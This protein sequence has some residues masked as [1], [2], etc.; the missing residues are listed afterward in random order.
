MRNRLIE[1]LLLIFGPGV[2]FAQDNE[3]IF[4]LIPKML[5]DFI[6]GIQ[7]E[8][9][10]EWGLPFFTKLKEEY[11]LKILSMTQGVN[12]KMEMEMNITIWR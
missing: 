7:Y 11:F 1:G 6:Q 5:P 3:I 2:L 8:Q 9:E 4:T 12:W 10:H